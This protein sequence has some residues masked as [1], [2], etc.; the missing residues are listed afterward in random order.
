MNGILLI[1][2]NLGIEATQA[3]EAL[4]IRMHDGSTFP[5]E[6]QVMQT[7]KTA[8]KWTDILSSVDNYCSTSHIMWITWCVLDIS[9]LAQTLLL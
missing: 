5:F 8:G 7:G 1:W 6:R 3:K 2:R 9:G 4:D